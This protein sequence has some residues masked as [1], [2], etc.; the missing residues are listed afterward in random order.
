MSYD[1]TLS[2]GTSLDLKGFE[3]G[4]KRL[5]SFVK[6]NQAFFSSVTSAID[7]TGLLEQKLTLLT[8]SSDSAEEALAN[9]TAGTASTQYGLGAAAAAMDNLVTHG[10]ALDAATQAVNIWGNA[11]ALYAGGSSTALTNVISALAS[12]QTAG[13]VSMSQITSLM[14]AGIPVVELYAQAMGISITEANAALNSGEVHTSNF[15]RVMNS[16]ITDSANRLP[17]L[18]SAATLASS[19]WGGAFESMKASVGNGAASIINSINKTSQ[20][21][22]GPTIQQGIASF[23]RSFENVLNQVAKLAVPVVKNFDLIG[24]SIAAVFQ[25]LTAYSIVTAVTNGFNNFSLAIEAAHQSLLENAALVVGDATSHQ[26]LTAALAE[27]TMAEKIKAAAKAKGLII[28][29]ANNLTTLAGAAV[30]AKETGALLASCGALTTKNVLVAALSGKIGIV[31]AAQ[32]LWNAALNANPLGVL[33]VIM[34]AFLTGLTLIEKALNKGSAD[35]Q[36][37]EAAIKDTASAYDELTQSMQE[38]KENF[39]Q[40]Q[41]SLQSQK[42]RVKE[43]TDTLAKLSSKEHK[44]AADKAQLAQTVALLNHQFDGLNLSIDEETG[45]LSRSAGEVTAYV[46]AQQQIDESSAKLDRYN[47]LLREQE[48]VE[49]QIENVQEHRQTL[50]DQHA[51]G[52]ISDDEYSQLL[53]EWGAESEKYL[54]QRN[55]I[56]RELNELNA[57]QT[58]AQAAFAQE[59]I[60]ILNQQAAAEAEA[61]QKRADAIGSF[62]DAATNMF[63]A[64]NEKSDV[65]VEQMIENLRKNGEAMQNYEINMGTLRERFSDLNLDT[66][67]L[68]Q[69]ANMGPEGI[70][71]VAELVKGSDDQLRDLEGY[72]AE[73]M[74]RAFQAGITST[75]ENAVLSEE[76]MLQAG[77]RGVDGYSTGVAPL[78]E[79]IAGALD[80]AADTT[81]TAAN[82][83]VNDVRDSMDDAVQQADFSENGKQIVE[84]T[85]DGVTENTTELTAATE[86]AVD[87]AAEAGAEEVDAKNREFQGIGGQMISYII[88]GINGQQ[89]A[90][91]NAVIDVVRAAIDAGEN[92]KST[93]GSLFGGGGGGKKKPKPRPASETAASPTGIPMMTPRAMLASPILAAAPAGAEGLAA[94]MQAGAAARQAQF[95]L[96]MPRPAAPVI[97]VQAASAAGGSGGNPPPMQ[98]KTIQVSIDAKNVK[99]FNDV[100]KVAQRAV[101]SYRMGYV[102][103]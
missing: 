3:Q 70:P 90:L 11:V 83:M 75:E 84:N 82:G 18:S 9:L 79:K 87:E 33:V 48:E 78:P 57:G 102:D 14:N 77:A 49:R 2:F 5:E 47:E 63:D 23:G 91:S 28:D 20:S 60:D 55:D 13:T 58:A 80:E 24:T 81:M 35:Y 27:E 56:G 29:E 16:A 1:G 86:S 94:R 62:T 51:S 66:A 36:A 34:G 41:Q 101:M 6:K 46:Q 10:M 37:H 8:G 88:D 4:I 89:K 54:V 69:L 38:S 65:S 59:S 97:Q 15:M 42:S 96:G 74:D 68:D 31:T 72:M 21:I 22:G 45:A 99:E 52:S 92:F 44:S 25:I 76:A 73:D 19:T 40:T 61:Q 12:M 95:S 39:S 71:Y 32:W 64:V 93:Y 103:H 98:V 43:L 17:T 100:V 50:N 30:S 85:T 67:V 7:A 53:T 26:F